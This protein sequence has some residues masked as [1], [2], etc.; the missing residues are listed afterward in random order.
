MQIH[1]PAV[2]DEMVLGPG[3]RT[4]TVLN[5]RHADA[6][7]IFDLDG[8]LAMPW[9]AEELAHEVHRMLEGGRKNLMI[10][11]ADVPYADSAGIGALL[12]IRSSIQEAGG[13]LVLLSPQPR[14]LH[15]MER[16]RIARI[17]DFSESEISDFRM[18]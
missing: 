14:V 7:V 17:F 1:A 11:L 2:F 15:L 3:A 10:D 6:Y 13:K 4:E 5:F 12:A 9:V 16:L 8:P 18:P